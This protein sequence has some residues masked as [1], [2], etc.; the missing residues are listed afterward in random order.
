MPIAIDS[1]APIECIRCYTRRPEAF[2]LLRNGTQ[3]LFRCWL[4]GCIQAPRLR[5]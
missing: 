4:C 5:R 1:W 3:W 2:E